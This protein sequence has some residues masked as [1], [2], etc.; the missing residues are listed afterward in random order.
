MSQLQRPS[1]SH[2]AHLLC[3]CVFRTVLWYALSPQR[4]EYGV[5]LL[6]L[7]CHLLLHNGTSPKMDNARL[8]ARK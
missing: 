1:L 7:N 4:T 3:V 2:A 8:R 5:R 6:Q